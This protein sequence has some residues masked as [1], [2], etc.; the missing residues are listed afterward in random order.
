MHTMGWGRYKRET[1]PVGGVDAAVVA[2]NN[3]YQTSGTPGSPDAF[4]SAVGSPHNVAAV[5]VVRRASGIFVLSL[6][7]PTTLAGADTETFVATA[8]FGATASGGTANGAWLLGISSPITATSPTGTSPMTLFTGQHGA[9]N[10]V[11]TLVLTGANAVAVPQGAS[12]IIITGGTAGPTA[13]TPGPL[14]A[15]AYELP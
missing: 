13:L 6:Q 4:T 10:L 5:N 3:R 8:L 14:V 2:L 12:C 15:I 9:G 7:M 1:Y 11:D